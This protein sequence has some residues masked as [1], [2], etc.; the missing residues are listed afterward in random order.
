MSGREVV[1]LSSALQRRLSSGHAEPRAIP[2]SID[3]E[4]ALLGAILVNNDAYYRVSDF[5]LAEH[6]TEEAHQKIFSVAASLIRAGTVATPITMKTYLGDADFGG[7]T[8]TQYLAR[9]AADATTVIN[10]GAYG[11]TIHDLALRR[12]LIAVG[13]DLAERACQASLDD[14]PAALIERT[15]EAL[16]DLRAAVPASHLDGRSAAEG[17]AW[18]LE[19][20]RGLRDGLI[21]TTAIPSGLVELDRA[22][23]GGFQRG[24]LWILAG[25]PGMGKTV[26]MTTLSR[27][28]AR[29]AG[30][31]V[32]QAEVTP[33][34]QWARYL[35]DLAYRPGHPLPFGRIMAGRDLDDEEIWR[36]EEAEKRFA[37]LHLHVEYHSP[38]SMAQ[39]AFGVKAQ[40]RKLARIGVRLG[41][42]FIDYLKFISASDRYQGQRVLEI[43]EI[44]GG[45]KQ[46][47]KAEDICVVLLA[48]LNREVDK[49]ARLDRRPGKEDL[50]DSGELEQDADAVLLVYREAVYLERKFKATNDPETG[51]RL[52]DKQNSLELILGKNRAGPTPTLHLWCDMAHSAIA[53]TTRGGF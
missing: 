35:A 47:A 10:A 42:V 5:L 29:E 46:L 20:V 40:K 19:R 23:N 41:V 1:Q 51:A 26:A 30:V 39:I 45:L 53:Q 3:A 13:E 4:Q 48:Q 11:R 25:R 9:L 14:A 49:E 33:E 32:F 15:E 22:T 8:V 36:L 24:E 28:A 21:A 16:L 2:H 31:L 43:G 34:Q 7:Q 37:R 50:R 44:S 52:I 17:G 38:V 12:R 27:Q 6:F 18:M